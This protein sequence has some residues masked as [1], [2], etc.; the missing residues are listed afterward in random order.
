M[1]RNL[2][3]DERRKRPLRLVGE[4][5]ENLDRPHADCP[6]QKAERDETRSRIQ[7]ALDGLDELTRSAVVLRY[8][9]N[10]SSKEIAELLDLTPAAV[11][12]RL[13]RAR[14]ELKSR[15]VTVEPI[16]ASQVGINL[17]V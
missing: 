9:E 13:S 6:S 14:A 8:Y 16:D 3:I 17:S 11:D 2:A 10:L 4:F 12:M 15:L 5:V 7:A 1:V